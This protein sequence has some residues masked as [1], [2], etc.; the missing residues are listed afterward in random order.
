MFLQILAVLKFVY[1]VKRPVEQ[2][3]PTCSFSC[4]RGSRLELGKYSVISRFDVA[5]QPPSHFLAFSTEVS[6][7]ETPCIFYYSSD[8][9]SEK[10]LSLNLEKMK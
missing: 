2:D 6:C 8:F 4:T 7:S 5:I 1:Q 9:L 3:A 10:R